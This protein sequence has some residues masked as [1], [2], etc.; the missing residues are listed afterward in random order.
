[1]NIG[2]IFAHLHASLRHAALM[3][4]VMRQEVLSVLKSHVFL[5]SNL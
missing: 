5:A 2:A 1:M 4:N 3:R